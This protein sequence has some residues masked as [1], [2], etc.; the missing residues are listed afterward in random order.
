MS[1][2]I[3][4]VFIILERV[5]SFM[6]KCFVIILE[7]VESR[8]LKFLVIFMNGG[9]FAGKFIWLARAPTVPVRL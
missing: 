8:M 6:L 1:D 3:D 2:A 4:T 5:E 7:R 9:K